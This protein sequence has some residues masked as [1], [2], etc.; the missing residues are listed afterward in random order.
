MRSTLLLLFIFPLVIYG[1]DQ[2]DSSAF[3]KEK[4][5]EIDQKGKRYFDSLWKTPEYLEAHAGMLRHRKHSKDYTSF[6]L[7]GELTHSDFK[8]FNESIA[9]SGFGPLNEYGSRFSMGFTWKERNHLI[10]FT[11]F[12]MGFWHKSKKGD[13]TIKS[14]F[15]NFL[16][17]SYGYALV[18]S[19]KT[20]IYP[21]GG[22]SFR[23][24]D[25]RYDAPEDINP[26][27]TN[28]TNLVQNNRSSYLNS[29]K[30]GYEAGLGFDFLLHENR[31][32]TAGT[33]LCLKLATNG[34]IGKERY[35]DNHVNYDPGIRHG[36]W[37]V[38]LGFKFFGRN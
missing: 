11:V 9:A 10:D 28:P 32:G 31:Y 18:S 35:K 27:F 38:A 34:A 16:Q 33:M 7:L 20:N 3:F 12:D 13:E 2:I 1:Q 22:I 8:K 21:Y 17:L 14:S 15:T 19:G 29:A 37:L 30:L 23:N 26:S 5:V 4:M 24:S 36:D 25:L 6:T